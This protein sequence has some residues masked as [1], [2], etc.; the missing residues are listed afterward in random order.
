M[1]NQT[2]G[3]VTGVWNPKIPPVFVWM[4]I[5]VNFNIVIVC[6]VLCVRII[7]MSLLLHCTVHEQFRAIPGQGV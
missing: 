2:R 4:F 6:Y 5:S 7:R 1:A 3:L